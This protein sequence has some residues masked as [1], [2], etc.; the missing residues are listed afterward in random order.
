MNQHP[1]VANDNQNLTPNTPDM[2]STVKHP[3][4][5]HTTNIKHKLPLT[6]YNQIFGQHKKPSKPKKVEIIKDD[7]SL[8]H[9]IDMAKLTPNYTPDYTR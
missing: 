3:A 6:L 1:S 2:V 9:F 7:T 4:F 8:D 5:N